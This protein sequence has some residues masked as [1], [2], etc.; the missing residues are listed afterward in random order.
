MASSDSP[1]AKDGGAANNNSIGFSLEPPTLDTIPEGLPS[2]VLFKMFYVQ[3]MAAGCYVVGVAGIV[4]L[5][6]I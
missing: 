5:K 2:E 6:I 4:K 1:S 3:C